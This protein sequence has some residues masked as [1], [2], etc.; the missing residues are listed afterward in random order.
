MRPGAA[1]TPC[2]ACSGTKPRQHYLCRHCWWQL[3]PAARHALNRRDSKATL[4]RLQLHR[5][6]TDG[7]PLEEIQIGA[8]P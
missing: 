4:R 1:R 3:S 2:P 7:V 6:L 5:Q 8:Q